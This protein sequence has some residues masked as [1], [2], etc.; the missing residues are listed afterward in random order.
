MKNIFNIETVG[1]LMWTTFG[2]VSAIGAYSKAEYWICGIM[3]LIAIFYS[4]RLF[5]DLFLHTKTKD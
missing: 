5:I 3:C 1:H 4:V 2:V